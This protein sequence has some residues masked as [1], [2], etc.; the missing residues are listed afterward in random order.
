MNGVL[1]ITP[2]DRFIPRL[3][4]WMGRRH[5]GPDEALL[6]RPC[7]G[8]HS[9]FM[10]SAID[11]VFLDGEARVIRMQTLPTWRWAACRGAA[12]TLE[13]APGAARRLGPASIE[14]AVADVLAPTSRPSRSQTLSPP[15]SRAPPARHP[16]RDG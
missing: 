11:V 3:V 2:A 1:R 7:A 12:M 9:C 16:V 10:R 5:I 4:G 6:L 13:M 8:V 14:A 15:R